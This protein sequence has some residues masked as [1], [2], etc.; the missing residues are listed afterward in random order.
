M[1]FNGLNVEISSELKTHSPSKISL[2]VVHTERKLIYAMSFK[3]FDSE[4]FLSPVKVHT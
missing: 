1:F 4:M 3:D 2:R